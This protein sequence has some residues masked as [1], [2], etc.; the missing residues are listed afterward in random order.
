MGLLRPLLDAGMVE[1]IGGKKTGY[2]A[3]CQP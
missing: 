1:K 3:L 2:Y